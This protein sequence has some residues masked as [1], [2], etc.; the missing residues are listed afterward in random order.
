[1][2]QPCVPTTD[3]G[4]GDGAAETTKPAATVGAMSARPRRDRFGRCAGRTPDPPVAHHKVKSISFIKDC[5]IRPNTSPVH[6]RKF[7]RIPRRQR[8]PPSR[9]ATK[10]QPRRT[11]S[12]ADQHGDGDGR[13]MVDLSPTTRHTDAVS[14]AHGGSRCRRRARDAPGHRAGRKLYGDDW[15]ARDFR[16]AFDLTGCRPAC[17]NQ[18]AASV[19]LGT[20]H[21][22][23]FRQ[24]QAIINRMQG[25]ATIRLCHGCNSGYSHRELPCGVMCRPIAP[26][27]EWRHKRWAMLRRP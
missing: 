22:R 9:P 26:P 7:R 10:R 2:Q 12:G 27:K 18:H 20:G 4:A 16:I 19:R 21:F 5:A 1:V 8:L 6:P 15:D 25:I 23:H 14:P 3:S 24:G 13:T 11:L 17:G